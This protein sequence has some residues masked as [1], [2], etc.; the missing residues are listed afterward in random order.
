MPSNNP[1]GKPR[2]PENQRRKPVT[3]RLKPDNIGKLKDIC[4]RTG[5]SQG[6]QIDEWIERDPVAMGPN[7]KPISGDE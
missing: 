7:E 5:N 3:V 6:G 4:K 2:L 1:H